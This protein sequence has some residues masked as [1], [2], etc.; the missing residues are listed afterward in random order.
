MLSTGITEVR[1]PRESSPGGESGSG[2]RRTMRLPRLERKVLTLSHPVLTTFQSVLLLLARWTAIHISLAPSFLA[3]YTPCS[4]CRISCERPMRRTLNPKVL[5]AVPCY[6]GELCPP[7]PGFMWGVC[8]RC[9]ENRQ[10]SNSEPKP[11]AVALRYIHEVLQPT[12]TTIAIFPTRIC[13]QN[14]SVAK[15]KKNWSS[16]HKS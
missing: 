8:I 1:H 4:N 14:Y 5:G 10:V 13:K 12:L 6:A 9:G 16:R 3:P 7:H 2:S 11:A 15:C